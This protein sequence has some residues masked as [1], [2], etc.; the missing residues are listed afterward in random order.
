M[1]PLIFC[2][3]KILG[4]AIGWSSDD[5]MCAVFQPSAVIAE[6]IIEIRL[7]LCILSRPIWK[8]S[9]SVIGFWRGSLL[10]KVNNLLLI[11]K[12]NFFN[13]VSNHV[14]NF[15]PRRAV[16]TSSVPWR[17]I[18]MDVRKNANFGAKNKFRFT[19]QIEKICFWRT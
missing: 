3:V 9:F 7:S 13:H 17:M 8:W 16:R 4:W 12:L 6:E 10:A 5:Q 18:Q 1:Y 19:L 2:I 15:N 14:N 11:L